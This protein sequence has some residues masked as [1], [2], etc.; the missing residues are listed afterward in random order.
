VLYFLSPAGEKFFDFKGVELEPVKFVD[1]VEVDRNWNQLAVDVS[2]H[3]VLI[4]PP[5]GEPGE[6]IE[7]LL[8]VRVEDVR[9]VSVNQNSG[10]VVAII[11]VAADM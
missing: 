2:Q 4:L 9:P 8:R 11:G 6:V 7:N 5:T 10:V 3:L 1:G